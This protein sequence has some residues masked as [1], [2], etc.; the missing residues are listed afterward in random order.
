MNLK[1]KIKTELY[2]AKKIGVNTS[3]IRTAYN[4]N[5][6]AMTRLQEEIM[7]ERLYAK[8]LRIVRKLKPK[9]PDIARIRDGYKAIFYK[10]DL[11][12]VPGINYEALTPY[13]NKGSAA[14]DKL[15]NRRTYRAKEILNGLFEYLHPTRARITVKLPKKHDPH[16]LSI[17]KH[18]GFN[19]ADYVVC[20]PPS[21]FHLD[22]HGT[23]Q[24]VIKEVLESF[25]TNG[26]K[27]YKTNAWNRTSLVN[28]SQTPATLRW[29]TKKGDIIGQGKTQ[30]T[31]LASFTTKTKNQTVK[32]LWNDDE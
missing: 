1:Q 29:F 5:Y 2:K 12:V 4:I 9:K 13:V 18:I 17:R 3:S 30:K 21:W 11:V 25:E 14:K 10:D 6:R 27:Y 23:K 20:M 16:Y 7:Y 31:A 19:N 28:S 26:I 15:I 32:T 22:F 8:E 24:W